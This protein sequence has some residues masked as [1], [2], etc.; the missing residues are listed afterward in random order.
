LGIR[1]GIGKTRT[2]RLLLGKAHLGGV[3]VSEWSKVLREMC[4][5]KGVHLLY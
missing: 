5:K 1:G 4:R 2:F 3:S